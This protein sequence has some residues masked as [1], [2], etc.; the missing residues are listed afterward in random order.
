MKRILKFSVLAFI[1]MAVFSC[2]QN[3]GENAKS[4]ACVKE[5]ASSA[6][7]VEASYDICASTQDYVALL[8]PS[9]LNGVSISDALKNRRTIREFSDKK[10]SDQQ[11]SDLLWC[12]CGAN[13][14]DGKRTAPTARNAQEMDVYL[15]TPAAIYCYQAASHSLKLVK[16]GDFREKSGKQG[17]FIV[18]PVS[19]SIVA[20]FNKMEG[21]DDEAKQF[22]SATDAGFISQNI[23]L[24]ASASGLATVTCGN[25]DRPG[26]VELLGL[27]N[28][29]AILS[30]PVG[31]EAE[32]E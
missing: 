10:L 14:E 12:A 13:R 4:E 32:A 29:K 17:A 20:D 1:A 30:H 26:I 19:V 22:Y 7:V 11:I 24:Y 6:P 18:A 16:V 28:A 2:K 15:F 21:F 5:E 27:P 31:Y 25:I 8:P 9:N 23:Y 3:V